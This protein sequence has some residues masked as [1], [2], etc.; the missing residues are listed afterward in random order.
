MMKILLS[1]ILLC[2]VAEAKRPLTLQEAIS[3]AEQALDNGRVGDAISTAEKL[4]KSRGLTKDE[5]GRVEV[6]VARCKLVEGK[7]DV[8]EKLLAKHYKATP[9]DTR[10]GE[11]YARALDGAGKGEAAFALLTDL[12]KRDALAEGDSYWALAQLERKKGETTQA[13]A[14]AKLALEKP[15]VLQSDELEQAIHH[16]IDELS[17]KTK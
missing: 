8:S 16:F 1:M 17:P 6:I 12:A 9:D 15:I 5:A 4:Q 7:Y 11:W 10:L 14:H 3:D 13:R 2:G